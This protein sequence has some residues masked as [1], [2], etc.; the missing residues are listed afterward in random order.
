[1]ATRILPE[2]RFPLHL[3]PSL[4]NVWRLY[5][6][7]KSER[8]E[9][10]RTL[11]W[12]AFDRSRYSNEALHA[13]QLAWSHLVWRLFGR[14]TE[15]PA[16]LV[17]FCLER[18]RESDPKYF[19]SMRCT[20][21]A[22]HLDA[23]DRFAKCCGGLIAAPADAAYANAFTQALYREALDA[24]QSLDAYVAAHVAWADGLDAAL[25]AAMRDGATGPL[26]HALLA[27]MAADR[28]RQADFG[29]LYLS[30]RQRVW[31]DADRTAIT[32]RIEWVN[33][34][35]LAS[36]VL[37]PWLSGNAGAQEVS[38]A[39]AASATAGLGGSTA[40]AAL[41]VIRATCA[42]LSERFAALGLA[43]TIPVRRD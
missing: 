30:G 8:W 28:A 4:D 6:A 19:L 2:Y 26:A 13:A 36:G 31:Q 32:Q 1:M 24:E 41:G 14:L 39:N 21:D 37:T 35:L 11:E 18:G 22:K 29:W 38:A 12:A 42:E 27:H 3:E 5:H 9:P 25:T 34:R 40:E 23:C 16:L 7:G 17:R 10:S 20:E 43:V 33:E 15:S